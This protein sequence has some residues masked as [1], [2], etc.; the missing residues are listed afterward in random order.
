MSSHFANTDTS[1]KQEY[2]PLT[3]CEVMTGL[4]LVCIGLQVYASLYVC[5]YM[6]VYCILVSAILV[7]W[8]VLACMPL[9]ACICMHVC[10]CVKEREREN[11]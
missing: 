1:P 4:P 9:G 2:K 10:V 3:T 7:H 6:C 11:P 5:T 8:C